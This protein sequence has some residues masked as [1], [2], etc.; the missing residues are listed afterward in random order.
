MAENKIRVLWLCNLMPGFIAKA[1]GLPGTNKEGWIAGMSSVVRSHNDIELA[2]AFPC[3]Q[4]GMQ[5]RIKDI[6]YYGFLED[7]DHPESYDDRLEEQLVKIC[8]EYNPQVIHCFG[9]EYPHTL[10]LVRNERLSK[11]SV[12]HLQGIMEHYANAYYSDLPEKVIN[13]RT[14]RDIIRKDSIVQQKEKYLAR[15]KFEKEVLK[16]ACNVCGR[17]DFDR[18]YAL[19]VNPKVNY[20]KL[21]ET[22]REQFYTGKWDIDKAKKNTIFVSQGN[23]PLKGVH[24]AIRSVGKLKKKYPDIKMYVSGDNVTRFET[25]KEKIKLSSYGKY[26][27]D[28]IH[29]ND[30][31][32]NVF[33]VG[34]KDADE[35]KQLYLESNLFLVSSVLENSPNSL[36]EAMMLGMPVV[37]ARVGGIPSMV[38]DEQVLL[39]EYNDVDQMADCIDKILSDGEFAVR[40]GESGQARGEINHGKESNYQAMLEIYK[41]ISSC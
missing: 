14:F 8:E 26:L 1:L 15:A 13:R 41:T 9:T 29:E 40:L 39:Y 33:F 23:Y 18:E 37:S 30:L 4:A 16:L 24:F 5:G 36:G 11:I 3:N 6:S 32:D 38:T 25:L 20:Y 21:G 34:Q 2:F 31:S 35:M 10:A 7:G 22:L 17:T 12:I 27:R 19:S 28:L